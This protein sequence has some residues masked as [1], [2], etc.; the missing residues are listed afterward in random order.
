MLLQVPA[1][2][3]NV[4]TTLLLVSEL[5]DFS[6]ASRPADF[7]QIKSRVAYNLPRFSANYLALF[8]T[9]AVYSLVVN[10]KLLVELIF[11]AIILL[12]G[13]VDSNSIEVGQWPVLSSHAYILYVTALLVILRSSL[14][15]TLLSIACTG[16]IVM[17]AHASL[18]DKT[19]IES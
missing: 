13:S 9:L 17:L 14:L 18:M 15:A 7:K 16:S 4:K 2:I 12:I 11:I 10:W 8:V 19:G 6:H 5:F 1:K 3:S